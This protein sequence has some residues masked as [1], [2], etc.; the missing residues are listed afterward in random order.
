MAVNIDNTTRHT[1]L[2]R[3]KNIV[4]SAVA[5]PLHNHTYYN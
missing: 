5:M 1:M 2:F 3:I 4:N